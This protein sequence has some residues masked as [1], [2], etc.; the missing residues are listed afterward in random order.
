LSSLSQLAE[1]QRYRQL[2]DEWL[3][4]I[5]DRPDTEDMGGA[6]KVLLREGGEAA[7][8]AGSLL[9][10][11]LEE[12][13]NRGS[14]ALETF[15]KV[16]AGLFDSSDR[17]RT[18]LLDHLR[19]EYL[20][21]E[22]LE[23]MIDRSGL[24]RGGSIRR[25]WEVL[26]QLLRYRKGAFVLHD[27]FGPGRIV[28]IR[29][30]SATVDFQK[31]A[32]HD[33]ALEALLDTTRPVGGD[34]LMVLHW[35]RP[36]QL[37][38]LVAEEP[39]MLLERL[40][41]E[42]GGEVRENHVTPLL[43]GIDEKPGHLWKRLRKA[44]ADNPETMDLGASIARISPGDLLAGARRALL[45]PAEP[46]AD[47]VTRLRAILA[48]RE[49]EGPD[50]EEAAALAR[51]AAELETPET[52]ARWEAAWLL[53]RASGKPVELPAVETAAA[54]ALRALGEISDSRC[55]RDYVRALARVLPEGE[56]TDLLRQMKAKRRE[57]LLDELISERSE[58]AASALR[59]LAADIRQ[60]GLYI[61]SVTQALGRG[62]A[63][64]AGLQVDE[65]LTAGLLEAIEYAR[66]S[67]QRR[68]C[69]L[70]EGELQDSLQRHLSDLDTRRL[71]SL[72]QKLEKSTA[73]HETG[74][75]LR[76]RREL[77]NR[78]RSS[79]S[80][81]RRFWE[82]EAVFAS[83]EAI[84]RRR[85]MARRLE[86]VEIPAAAEAVGEAASHGDLSENAEYE[87]AIERRDMLLSRLR[88]YKE[89]LRRVRPYPVSDVSSRIC[90][91]GTA[92]TLAGGDGS[93]LSYS[94]VGPLD[95]APEEGRIN[96]RSPLGAALLGRRKGDEVSLPGGEGVCVVE[97]IEVLPE[98]RGE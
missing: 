50:G 15:L 60:P 29:R 80:S 24:A 90:S 73:A 12:L 71:S 16:A 48:S 31:A 79:V 87:A 58:L 81:S 33:M 82:S 92:V 91:P 74:L 53:S 27:R 41:R 26:R 56:V 98:V 4:G 14:P 77:S 65:G 84:A 55:V 43:E 39:D 63:G 8:L 28:R 7:E 85:E 96:Y 83:T 94:L 59:E 5:E 30:S 54:R 40:L 45:N 20:T 49:G 64:S 32:D 89:E 22:P 51:E 13:E 69:R 44:A 57:W 47:R 78:R 93:R 6:L 2:E 37:A 95:A 62:M 10:L 11:T 1:R 38:E 72:A 19:D 86:K 18:M 34:S 25:G 70:L 52:G 68:A 97:S 66:T 61:W 35:K 17:L 88:D 42:H 75:L 76:V 3:E 21:Y 36:R 9:S 46:L 23:R 67:E